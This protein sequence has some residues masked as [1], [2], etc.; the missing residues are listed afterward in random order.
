M[1]NFKKLFLYL[2]YLFWNPYI[3][4]KLCC[5]ETNDNCLF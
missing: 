4:N 2:L 3:L 5:F 1:K